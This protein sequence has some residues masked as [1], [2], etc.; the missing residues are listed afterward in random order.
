MLIVFYNFSMCWK[1]TEMT[2]TVCTI[3]ASHVL[4]VYLLW[5]GGYWDDRSIQVFLLT[6]FSSQ[7]YVTTLYPFEGSIKSRDQ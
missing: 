3:C 7:W 2:I 5:W 4:H 1:G 6:A